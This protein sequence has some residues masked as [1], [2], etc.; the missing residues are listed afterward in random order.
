MSLKLMMITN[1]EDIAIEAEKNGVDRIFIDLEINGKKDRQG[2]LDTLISEHNIEDVGRI[3]KIIKNSEILVRIN[4]MY[5]G[6][7]EEIDKVIDLGADIIMLPM[8]KTVDEISKFIEI[9]DNR[10]QTCLLLETSQALA[11]LDDILEIDNLNEL[12]VG[13]NDLHLSLGLDFMFEL[14]SG[15]IVEYIS[16]KVKSK[17]IRF[18]FGGIAKVG[19]G[20]IPAEYIIREHTRLKSEMVILSRS[21]HNR[22]K[23]I[24]DIKNNLC[25]KTEIDKIRRIEQESSN[26]TNE[27]FHK[28]K[29]ELMRKIQ[30]ILKMKYEKIK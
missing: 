16:M 25:L 8:A 14:L 29:E 6:T 7:K 30:D 22:S 21:F 23:T 12:H 13:L 18:G 15:G 24:D 5:E 28:N 10:A 26:F 19:E 4:P 11:R 27:D 3:R 20:L 2:H 9:V 17:G 1:E